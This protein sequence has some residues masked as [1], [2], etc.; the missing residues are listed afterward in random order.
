MKKRFKGILFIFSIFLFLSLSGVVGAASSLEIDFDN[1]NGHAIV[2]MDEGQK[3]VVKLKIKNTNG[4]VEYKIT[5]G[6]DKELFEFDSEKL[7]LSFKKVADFEN[8]KDS[9]LDN[10]YRVSITITDSEKDM[11]QSF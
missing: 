5:G 8:P 7:L 11:R 10:V 9:N 2:K 1:M 3:E 6:A 4:Q